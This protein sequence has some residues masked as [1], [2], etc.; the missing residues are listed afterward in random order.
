MLLVREH[1]RTT[2]LFVTHDVD[3]AV[4]LS[5]RVLVMSPRPGRVRADLRVELPRARDVEQKLTPEFLALKREIV[6][7]LH[8]GRDTTGA[9]AGLLRR[10]FAG[11]EASSGRRSDEPS[12]RASRCPSSCRADAGARARA[13]SAEPAA[14]PPTQRISNGH[15]AEILFEEA[16]RRRQALVVH[17]R[18]RRGHAPDR[19]PGWRQRRDALLQPAQPARALQR[20]RHAEVPAHVQAVARS[21]P[22]L[23]HGAHLLLDHRGFGRLARHG[24]RQH[25]R[26]RW[27][28]RA[29]VSRA[30]R[31]TATTGR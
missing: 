24:L 20:A 7:M 17:H 25:Q 1:W 6:G 22:L 27:S 9:R 29:G 28:R 8:E 5:D 30:I 12:V 21:L 2:I 11:A 10:M 31:S 26:A 4:F 14:F 13:S 15:T 3:E 16:D 23:R 19:R 18:A